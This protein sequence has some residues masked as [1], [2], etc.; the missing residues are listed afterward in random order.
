MALLPFALHLLV[1]PRQSDAA[2]A[3][4]EA[5]RQLAGLGSWSYGEAATAVVLVIMLGL[6]M[7]TAWHHQPT[8]TIALAGVA[9]LL[10]LGVRTWRQM[11][12]NWAAWDALMWLGGLVTMANALRDYGVIDWLS[13]AIQSHVAGLS[14]VAVAVALAVAYFYSMYGFSMLTGHIMAMGS[15]L[16]LVAVGAGA[17]PLLIVALI[18]YFSNL[19]GCL[20]NYSTGPLVIYFGLGRV[21]VGRWYLAGFLVSLLHMAV[22]LGVGLPYWK[23]LGWW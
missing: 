14:G 5:R 1:K 18:A 21:T 6:W 16:M 10:V 8:T 3:R 23:L 7:T 20:T 19:C 9:A 4:R 13:A 17:P 15:A 2:A 22:W 12:G 11:A